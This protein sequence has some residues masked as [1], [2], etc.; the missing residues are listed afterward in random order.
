ME[1]TS[2]KNNHAVDSDSKRVPKVTE[3][4]KDMFSKAHFKLYWYHLRYN[5]LSTDEDFYIPVRSN[6]SPKAVVK[7]PLT[8]G[9]NLDN[10]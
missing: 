5:P 1:T 2:E 8:I 6:I 7:K 3:W 4:Q 9:M 10:I